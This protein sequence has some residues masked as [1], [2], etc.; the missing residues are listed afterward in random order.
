MP[1]LREGVLRAEPLH[2]EGGQGAVEGEDPGDNPIPE[3]RHPEHPRREVFL[4]VGSHRLPGHRQSRQ[5]EEKEAF[6]GGLG[7]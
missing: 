5:G 7:R 2:E 6:Q 4:R 1:V 3:G